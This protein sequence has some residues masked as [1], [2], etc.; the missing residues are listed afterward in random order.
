MFADPLRNIELRR[1]CALL[2]R[3]LPGELEVLLLAQVGLPQP[4]NH[5]DDLDHCHALPERRQSADQLC[6]SRRRLVWKPASVGKGAVSAVPTGSL[7]GTRR[8]AH[9]TRKARQESPGGNR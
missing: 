8:F 4:A 2:Q 1:Y 9:P 3:T 6:H 5:H 7:V